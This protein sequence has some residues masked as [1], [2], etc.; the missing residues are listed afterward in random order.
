MKIL[1]IEDDQKLA[2][3]IHRFLKKEGHLCESVPSFALGKQKINN[4]KYDCAIIDLE[5]PDGDGFKLIGLLRQMNV[6]TG[7]IVISARPSLEE[8]IRSLD[9][10][11][12]DFLTKPFHISELYA[13]IKAIVR[14]RT[15]MVNQE[16]AF[17][18]LL[19]RIDERLV[20]ANGQMLSLTKKEFE[21]LL[22]LARNKN[23]VI[24]KENLAEFL[25]GDYVD[26]AVSFDFIYTHVKNLRKKL[27]DNQCATFLQTV[28]GVGY[29]FVS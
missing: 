21:I 23:R 17:E 12:D 10:G 15:N 1:L 6:E 9:A 8:R 18:N 29:K 13:R 28:Y 27:S 22:Y 25:W 19:I 14:R 16:L 26:E 5:L 4:Y 24:S 3:L 2:T 7:Q 20:F 11:A